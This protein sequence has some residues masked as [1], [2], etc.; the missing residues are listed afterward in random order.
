MSESLCFAVKAQ[1]ALIS[2]QAEKIRILEEEKLTSLQNDLMLQRQVTT[3]QSSQLDVL[4][5]RLS[6][7]T[8]DSQ[9][10][11][12]VVFE[13]QRTIKQLIKT[14]MSLSKSLS[15]KHKES[16]ENVKAK[17]SKLQTIGKQSDS[18]RAVNEDAV[19]TSA[20]NVT[21]HPVV[22]F[23]VSITTTYSHIH[24]NQSIPF[25]RIS[26]NIGNAYQILNG[27][28]T[29]PVAGIYIFSTTVTMTRMT[30]DHHMHVIIEKNG[31]QIAGA[32]GYDDG[33][34]VQSSVTV[35]AQLDVGDE[36]YV[37]V[38]RHND[39]RFIGDNLTS[40]MGCLIAPL[41]NQ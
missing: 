23:E 3:K 4:Q 35:V 27:H 22:A 29:A 32:Y 11:D 7:Y 15:N 18:V 14:Q 39:I 8:E 36:V 30:S 34:M 33:V 10:L 21:P 2:S 25:H 1:S 17:Q 26:L 31:F 12:N 9:R 5:Q 24:I 13:Q 16:E 19:L 40:F 41:L 38:E 28:F 6:K 37:T 20:G